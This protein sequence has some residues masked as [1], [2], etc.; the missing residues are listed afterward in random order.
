MA[1]LDTEVVGSEQA[2][3]ASVALEL[4]QVIAAAV[5]VPRLSRCLAS[6]A[7]VMQM[8]VRQARIAQAAVVKL[9]ARRT[10]VLQGWRLCAPTAQILVS[11]SLKLS[12]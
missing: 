8:L 3:A 12:L 10:L 2:G 4:A 6:A 11:P 1:N 5:K 7:P 9:A